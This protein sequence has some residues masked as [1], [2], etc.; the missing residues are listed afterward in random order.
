MN[1]LKII[2]KNK[3]SL[4]KRKSVK[5]MKIDTNENVNQGSAKLL[6]NVVSSREPLS[7]SSYYL[8]LLFSFLY[9]QINIFS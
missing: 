1:E 2:K 7:K 3:V 8:H 5:K 6:N 9:P 4:T